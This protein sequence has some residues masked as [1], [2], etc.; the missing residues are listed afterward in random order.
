MEPAR[1]QRSQSVLPVDVSRFELRDGRMPA[2]RTAER[3]PDAKTAFGKV[4]S[5][6]SI[7]ANA[8]VLDPVNQRLIHAALVNEVLKK[9]ADGVI[10]KGR[11]NRRVESKAALDATGHVVLATTF[12]YLKSP[13][14]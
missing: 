10:G 6:S 8:V 12:G 1:P 3:R 5:I 4:Q 9:T 2:V 14:S 13:G 11:N 7:A